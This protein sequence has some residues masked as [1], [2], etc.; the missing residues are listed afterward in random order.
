MSSAGWTATRVLLIESHIHF[1]Q[2]YA[3][4][5]KNTAIKTSATAAKKLADQIKLMEELVKKL[6]DRYL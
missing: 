2:A 1:H 6:A 3:L 4:C 5:P